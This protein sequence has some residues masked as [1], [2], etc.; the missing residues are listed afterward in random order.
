MV[1]RS[2]AV[3]VFFKVH[4]SVLKFIHQLQLPCSQLSMLITVN[5]LETLSQMHKLFCLLSVIQSLFAALVICNASLAYLKTLTANLSAEAKDIVEG[6]SE[7]DS[8]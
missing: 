4:P 5:G 3:R 8:V 1:Q 2:D 7:I 6:V